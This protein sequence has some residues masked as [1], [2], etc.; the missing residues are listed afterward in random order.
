MYFSLIRL[1]RDISPREVAALGRSDDYGLHKLVWGLF[2]DGP[3]RRR[4]FL[5]RFEKV[6]GLPTFY[7]VSDRDPKDFAGLWDI[8]SKH[9]APKLKT[10]D[11]LS[12]AV[13][14]NPIRSKRDENGRQH[15]HDV[16]ME[17]K[18]K[19]EFKNP[20]DG[21]RPHVATVIQEAGMGW[22]KA[23]ESE[24]GFRASDSGIRADGYVQRTLFKAKG[25]KSV[26][27]STL[28]FNGVLTVTEPD[29]FIGKCLFSGI[30]PAKAFGCGLMLVRRV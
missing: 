22:L 27:F 8:H 9:Y 14:V 3:E 21:Q 16:V 7:T 4:D 19:N 17:A 26:N 20:P 11:R 13:R 15:R 12:F 18:K 6:K 2:S 1:R 30:G 23:R 25:A 28:E 10:G 29:V 5:Y 24:L